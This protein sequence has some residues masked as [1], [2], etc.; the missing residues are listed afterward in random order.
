MTAKRILAVENN[1]L[2]LS[3]LEA[4]LITAGYDVDTAS[5][6]REALEM[7]DDHPYD[8]IISDVRMPELDG[9]GLCRALESRPAEA[10]GRLVLLADMDTIGD[11]EDFLARSGVP[12]LVK[13]FALEELQLLVERMLVRPEEPARA[14]DVH[15]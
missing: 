6:G 7:I 14:A 10:R 13:P 2:V 12:A 8:L 1:E 9:V 15:S 3:F 4:G 11:H 5:N